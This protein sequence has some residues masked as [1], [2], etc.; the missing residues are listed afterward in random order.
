MV[1]APFERLLLREIPRVPFGSTLLILT[2]V[3]N[4]ELIETLMSLKKH[5]RRITVLSVAEEAPPSMPGVQSLH[6]PYKKTQIDPIVKIADA[7]GDDQQ[8]RNEVE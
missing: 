3:M 4:Q 7:V 5:E 2:A 1:V 6:M 8:S